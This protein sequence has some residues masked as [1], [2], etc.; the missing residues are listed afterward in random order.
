MKLNTSNATHFRTDQQSIFVLIPVN[1]IYV[2]YFNGQSILSTFFCPFAINK[3]T[4]HSH[5]HSPRRAKG[6]SHA[7]TKAKVIWELFYQKSYQLSCGQNALDNPKIM[8]DTDI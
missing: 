4:R 2:G 8:K 3:I 1:V 6:L 7:T 5:R